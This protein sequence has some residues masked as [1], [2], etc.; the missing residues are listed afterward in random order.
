MNGA[1]DVLISLDVWAT[2]RW[3]GEVPHYNFESATLVGSSPTRVLTVF[4]IGPSKFD[5]RW[6]I[7]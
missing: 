7:P 2:R 6:I 3:D 4:L 5:E 1:P